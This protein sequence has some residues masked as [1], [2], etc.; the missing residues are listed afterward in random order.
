MIEYP[1]YENDNDDEII[2][3]NAECVFERNCR[4]MRILCD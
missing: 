2:S 3:I 1:L 4:E